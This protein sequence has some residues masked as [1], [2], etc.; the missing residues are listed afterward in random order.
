MPL[1]AVLDGR[2]DEDLLRERTMPSLWERKRHVMKSFLTA[3]QART[4]LGT[5]TLPLHIL[6]DI[7]P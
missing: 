4:S 7:S 2:N 6:L 1:T 5:L 3:G